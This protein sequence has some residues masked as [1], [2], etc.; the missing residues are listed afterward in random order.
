MEKSTFDTAQQLQKKHDDLVSHLESVRQ[1]STELESL[2]EDLQS[3]HEQDADT[4][5]QEMDRLKQALDDT[6]ASRNQARAATE[7]AE[8]RIEA[9]KVEVVRKHMAVVGP[10]EKQNASL[11]DKNERLEAILAASDSITRAAAAVG[12]KRELHA[13]TEEDEEEN[14]STTNVR[15]DT[16]AVGSGVTASVGSLAPAVSAPPMRNMA[17]PRHEGQADV[18]GTVSGPQVWNDD[19]VKHA[20]Q[21]ANQLPSSWPLCRLRYNSLAYSTTTLLW[22]VTAWRKVWVW[23]SAGGN[24][25]RWGG[26]MVLS[27]LQWGS[28]VLCCEGKRFFKVQ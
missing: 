15:S 17:P 2:Y 21:L 26:A 8:E 12:E 16:D 27:A 11:R 10:L 7:R 18:V 6:E 19:E 24:S 14:S 9:M 13:L 22:R 3:R 4:H 1:H 20:T 25:L 23:V 28:A 5:V